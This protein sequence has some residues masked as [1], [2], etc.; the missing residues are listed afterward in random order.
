MQRLVREVPVV[1]SVR[2][3][4]LAIVRASRPGEE[5]AADEV[6]RLSLA[7]LVKLE[8]VP[9]P[10][11]EWMEWLYRQSTELCLERLTGRKR[12][13]DEWHKTLDLQKTGQP[14][15]NEQDERIPDLR[16]RLADLLDRIA[17]DARPAV[18]Y[19]YLDELAPDAIARL[20]GAERDLVVESLAR[21]HA[22]QAPPGPRL[23]QGCPSH[24]G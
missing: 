2:D 3:F 10:D 8:G 24:K 1:P 9:A 23:L 18:V 20:T 4:A 22:R 19:R 6:A 17:R 15:R 5:G 13:D 21:F 12:R 7:R 11:A 14:A 16:D